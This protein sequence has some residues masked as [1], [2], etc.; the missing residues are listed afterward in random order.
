MQCSL[1]CKGK[2]GGFVLESYKLIRLLGTG[3]TATVYLGVDKLSGKKYAVKRYKNHET[4]RQA[5]RERELLQELAH[6]AIPYVREVLCENGEWYEVMEY[7]AGE[8]LF[9]QIAEKKKIP[10]PDVIRWSIELCEVLSY[11]HARHPSI[12]YRD[13]KPANII[14]TP[15]GHVKLVDFGTAVRCSQRELVPMGTPGYAAPEQFERNARLDGRAD[16]YALGAVMYHMWTGIHP[17][18]R[19][20]AEGKLMQIVTRCMADGREHR[21]HYCEEVKYDLVHINVPRKREKHFYITRSEVI[22]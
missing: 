9:R 6:P 21:Y 1:E 7:V 4:F 20:A 2:M 8:T 10:Q 11:L 5:G 13:L 3:G 17:K 15:V 14:I 16:I 18:G 12:I 22:D 19:Q